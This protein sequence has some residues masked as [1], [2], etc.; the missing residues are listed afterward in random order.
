MCKKKILVTVGIAVFL[1]MTAFN[2]SLSSD[3]NAFSGLV[4]ANIEILAQADE[5]GG[6][7]C[8]VTGYTNAW[9]DGCL[10]YCAQCSEGYYVAINLIHCSAR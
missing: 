4:L 9:S 1:M 3:N 6:V 2:I 8:N 7:N 10:Y 5:I